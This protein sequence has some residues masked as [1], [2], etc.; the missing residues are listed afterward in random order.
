[1]VSQIEA[2]V[3]VPA[4]AFTLDVPSSMAELSLDELRQA[5]PL[6]TR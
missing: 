1:V 6:R 4:A 5:G 3:D 2:N